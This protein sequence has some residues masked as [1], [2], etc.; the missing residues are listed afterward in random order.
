MVTTAKGTPTH[1][2]IY[3]L[4]GAMGLNDRASARVPSTDA[5]HIRRCI[6]AGL[7]EVIGQELILTDAGKTACAEFKATWQ[8]RKFWE[9]RK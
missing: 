8:G 7:A 9:G 5:P 3:C 1:T 4:V 6:K 2:N